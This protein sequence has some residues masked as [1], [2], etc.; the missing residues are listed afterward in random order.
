MGLRPIVR[1]T[2]GKRLWA[3][4]AGYKRGQAIDIAVVVGAWGRGAVLRTSAIMLRTPAILL[5]RLA[6][7]FTLLVFTVFALLVFA[8]LVALLLA[9][10]KKL[11]VTREIGLRITRAEGGLIGRPDDRLP[12][13]LLVA[14]VEIV[15]AWISRTATAFRAVTEGLGLT[16]LVLRRSDQTKIMLGV[17]EVV[18]RRH[19]VPR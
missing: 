13:S 1:L 4:A 19:R 6:R 10:R 5:L 14:V 2:L 15:V 18:L 17:L 11:G 8:L 7:V 9:W 16:E 3:A 12:G